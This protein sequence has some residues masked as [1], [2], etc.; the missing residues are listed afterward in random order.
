MPQLRPR[1][2][3]QRRLLQVL[4][5]RREPGLLLIISGREE[6]AGNQV[7]PGFIFVREGCVTRQQKDLWDGDRVPQICDVAGVRHMR[8][9]VRAAVSPDV[10]I[11]DIGRSE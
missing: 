1:G 10:E 7:V 6:R 2:R 5:L 4:E 9:R 3:A 8:L 11:A